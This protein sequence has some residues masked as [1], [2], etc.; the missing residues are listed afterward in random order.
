MARSTFPLF[1]VA[2]A[3][4]APALA[5]QAIPVGSFR[6][7]QLAAGGDLTI[8]PGRVQRVTLLNGSTEF[9]RFN[10]RH[11]GRLEI[12]THCNGRCPRNYNLRIQIESPQVPDVAVK[13][14]G[15]IKVAP[16]FAPQRQVSAAVLAGGTIDLRAVQ[17][18]HASAAI[19]AGGD[20]YVGPS[21]RLNA[22]VNAG[23]DVRYVG[24]PQV[25]MA[26]ANGGNVRR[27]R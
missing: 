5:Q 17:A 14:G 11:D 10:I 15:T 21:A 19:N 18:T 22:A 1:L 6:S 13:A 8:V 24:N 16:G 27:D 7:V 4:S 12:S 20:I 9:T 3:A 25:S 23:G 26:V 2:L